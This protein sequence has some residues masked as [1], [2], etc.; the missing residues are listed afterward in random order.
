MVFGRHSLA[1]PSQRRVAGIVDNG[2]TEIDPL[3]LPQQYSA[4]PV[5]RP[6][7]RSREPVTA[8]SFLALWDRLRGQGP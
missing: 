1:E 8:E 4:A 7:A 6:Q 3:V 5:V 2:G